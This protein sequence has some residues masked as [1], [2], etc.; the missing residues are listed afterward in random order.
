MLCLALNN[1]EAGEV[2]MAII[3]DIK[4]GQ[5]LG[6]VLFSHYELIRINKVSDKIKVALNNVKRINL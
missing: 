4:K 6:Q 3:K 1:K 5:F 2:Q